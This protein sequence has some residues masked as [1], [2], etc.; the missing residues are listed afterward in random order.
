[1]GLLEKSREGILGTWK[2]LGVVAEGAGA[3]AEGPHDFVGLNRQLSPA[4]LAEKRLPAFMGGGR[5]R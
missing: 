5:L 1:M 4:G 2:A 3:P